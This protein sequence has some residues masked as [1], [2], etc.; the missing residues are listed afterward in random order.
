MDF[1]SLKPLKSIEK[2]TLFLMLGHSKNNEKTIPKGT[3]LAQD[4]FGSRSFRWDWNTLQPRSVPCRSRDQHLVLLHALSLR[5]A[6]RC[7]LD[8]RALAAALLRGHPSY[9]KG[10][11][12]KD[13]KVGTTTADKW[14]CRWCDCDSNVPK[15]RAFG[16]VN[17]GSKLECTWCN[18]PKGRAMNPP[19]GRL[20]SAA[21]DVGG[22]P[23]TV[24]TV[25]NAQA[26]APRRNAARSHKE[27]AATP[28]ATSSAWSAGPPAPLGGVVMAGSQ[29]PAP[30][31]SLPNPGQAID[32][33]TLAP[34]LTPALAV[35]LESLTLVT[36]PRDPPKTKTAIEVVD[37]SLGLS[38]ALTAA[39]GV[40]D[41]QTTLT[42]RQKAR[43]DAEGLPEPTRTEDLQRIDAQITD[44]NAEIA[45]LERKAPSVDGEVLSLEA[46]R[47]EFL[48]LAE[49]RRKNAA[50]CA[51]KALEAE[52][53]RSSFLDKLLAQH[54]SIADAHRQFMVEYKNK[55]E[56]RAADREDEVRGALAE[57]DKRIAAKKL[58]ATT[59]ASAQSDIS[60]GS[61]AATQQVA[62]SSVEA[63]TL[64]QVQQQ[65]QQ[66][67][68]EQQ[69]QLQQQQLQVKALQWQLQTQQAFARRTADPDVNAAPR[70]DVSNNSLMQACDRLL[71]LVQG[72][73]GAG[74]NCPFTF[75]DI[76]DTGE[77]T[78]SEPI[79][80]ITTIVGQPLAGWFSSQLGASDVLPQQLV[81]HLLQ[82]LES[83]RQRL[84]SP[85]QPDKSATKRFAEWA[86]A[87]TSK[88]GCHTE[89]AA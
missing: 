47:A 84:Q 54:A 72:W 19:Q 44:L 18:R 23:A 26:R 41:L 16:Q 82:V 53:L 15:Q 46:A 79:Q 63:Q 33:V 67:K 52:N 22:G 58:L 66:L 80:L 9:S 4:H 3:I 1:D 69:T 7:S 78:L 29:A 12:G 62:A 51:A 8:M 5:M 11:I 70:L 24:G 30:A 59:P 61:A 86:Q 43:I 38:K 75:K 25:T 49:S 21:K 60:F 42:I 55:H 35:F 34:D 83:L 36:P 64:A 37:E 13:S 2:Q 32:V 68:Q 27:T 85:G 28:Q 10:G 45:K 17:F 77:A 50:K 81:L 6:P 31:P 39:S 65:L 76:Q 71:L 40:S 73:S 74:G 57:F 89:V 14:R 87:L 56:R 20:A 48:V 88:R